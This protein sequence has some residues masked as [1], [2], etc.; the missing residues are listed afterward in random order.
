MNGVKKQHA[1]VLDDQT[2]SRLNLLKSIPNKKNAVVILSAHGTE[3]EAV[4]YAK[5]NFSK[6]Y[7]LT[8]KYIY[9][10][11]T[12]IKELLKKDNEIIFLG[13]KN[14]PETKAILSYSAKIIYIASLNELNKIK[15]KS[16]R[17]YFLLNQT[18]IPE[19]FIKESL[20]QIKCHSLH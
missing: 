13:K 20:K 18:T 16:D 7:D 15:F 1:I 10:N 12:L 14:H 19:S 3:V 6:C 5:N 2:K 9:K 17:Q 4:T 8:C 11:I